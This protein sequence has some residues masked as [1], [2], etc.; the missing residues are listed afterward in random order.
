MKWKLY[1]ESN[2]ADFIIK[3][4]VLEKYEGKGG[5]VVIPDGVTSI[6][7]WAFGDCSDLTS[8]TIPDSVTSI[9][10]GAFYKCSGLTSVTIGNSV[11]SIGR[12]AFQYCSGLTSVTI[13]DSVSNIGDYTFL[14]CSGL[15]SVTIGNGV[16]SIGDWAFLCCSELASVTIPNSVTSIGDWAFDGCSKLTSVIIPNSVESIGK[17]AFQGCNNLQSVTI[18]ENC[19]IGVCAFPEDWEDCE[20]CDNLQSVTIPENCEIEA[21]SFPE[22][23]KVIRQNGNKFDESKVGNKAMK[24]L[25]ITKEQFNRSRYFKNKYGSLKYVSESGNVFKTSKGNLLK[26]KESHIVNE[27]L[28]NGYFD[29]VTLGNEL[30]E[31]DELFD[32]DEVWFQVRYFNGRNVKETGDQWSLMWL[33][34]GVPISLDIGVQFFESEEDDYD[35]KN[36][37]QA[38]LGRIQNYLKKNYGGRFEARQASNDGLIR[39]VQLYG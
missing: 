34:Q 12:A 36:R 32:W 7:R 33:N 20:D 15:T 38:M 22:G 2:E 1:K 17:Y 21:R 19:E 13:P 14:G 28:S 35:N 26:F 30:I 10:E 3:D 27:S 11:T 9:G 5:K 31:H 25:N 18:P 8:V 37:F 6:E 29:L 16:T 23:C 39:I 24:K 4:G